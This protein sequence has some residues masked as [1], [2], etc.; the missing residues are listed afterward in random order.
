MKNFDSLKTE[1]QQYL[2]EQGFAVFHG[3]SR[4][5]SDSTLVDW[6]AERY[7]DFRQFLHIAQQL[8]VRLIVFHH[9]EFSGESVEE[10]LDRLEQADLP[11]DEKRA[12]ERRVKEISV[13]KGFTCALELSFDHQGRAYLFDLRTPW[14]EELEEIGDEIDTALP[15]ED[16]EQDGPI[17]GYFSRN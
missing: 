13:Y 15:E 8:D 10:L 11:R 4:A 5:F 1:I 7:P 17:G 16:P 6:D 3:Y 9:R 2:E 14:F 12:Y